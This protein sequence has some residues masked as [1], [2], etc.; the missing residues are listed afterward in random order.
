MLSPSGITLFYY[1]SYS[2]GM[3]NSHGFSRSSPCCRFSAKSGIS[4]LYYIARQGGKSS[5]QARFIAVLNLIKG[6]VV[7]CGKVKKLG[8]LLNK[9]PRILSKLKGEL[10]KW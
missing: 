6:R 8:N 3:S 5:F 10:K 4:P 7:A 2:R 9:L 1:F